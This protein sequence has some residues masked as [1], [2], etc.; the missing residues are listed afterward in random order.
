[1][2]HEDPTPT[3]LDLPSRYEDAILDADMNPIFRGKPEDVKAVLESYSPDYQDLV[4]VF[5]GQVTRI[6]SV[7]EYLSLAAI[8]DEILSFDVPLPK[9]KWNI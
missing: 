3:R 2:S 6:M 4:T 5:K 1:M 7:T 9:R 8:E